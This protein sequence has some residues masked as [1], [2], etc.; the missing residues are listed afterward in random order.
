MEDLQSFIYLA[1]QKE[2][3]EVVWLQYV[4]AFTGRKYKVVK[5][6]LI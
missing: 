6:F 4:S 2:N 3:W 1:Y 5:A